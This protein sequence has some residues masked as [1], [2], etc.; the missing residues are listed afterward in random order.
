ME[1]LTTTLIAAVLCSLVGFTFGHMSKRTPAPAMAP[2]PETEEGTLV[3]ELSYT[4]HPER[5]FLMLERDL[6]ALDHSDRMVIDVRIERINRGWEDAFKKQGILFGGPIH[7][8]VPDVVDALRH[9]LM[10]D[11]S[12]LTRTKA[13]E[14]QGKFH[15]EIRAWAKR[16]GMGGYLSWVDSDSPLTF[17]VTGK[18]RNNRLD[19]DEPTMDLDEAAR[20]K[21][22]AE[23]EA[24]T[25]KAR[26]AASHR[27]AV[28][29]EG[30]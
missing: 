30:S 11:D 16:S 25:H 6:A 8:T 10:D 26:I 3:L 29:G 18:V 1:P 20:R 15:P 9:L 21:A 4:C 17:I 23:V 2:P 24:L 14:R 22:E 28:R 13:N 19:E 12:S 7:G 5:F 27:V